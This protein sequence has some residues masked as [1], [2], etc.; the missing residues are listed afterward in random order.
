MDL[1]RSAWDDT[2]SRVL[3]DTNI[4]D[5]K[6]KDSDSRNELESLWEPFMHN[7]YAEFR[8]EFWSSRIARSPRRTAEV[9]VASQLDLEWLEECTLPSNADWDGFW[10]FYEPLIA[11]EREQIG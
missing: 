9:M 7:Q 2:A 6:A 8:A 3:A 5:I 10:K 1:L 11:R 4:I